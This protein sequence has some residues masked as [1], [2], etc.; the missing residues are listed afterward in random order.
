MGNV[1]LYVMHIL[2]VIYTYTH[3]Y[4]THDIFSIGTLLMEVKDFESLCSYGY[5]QEYR[6]ETLRGITFDHIIKS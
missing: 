5:Q 2:Y 3:M 6:A 1:S 4:I